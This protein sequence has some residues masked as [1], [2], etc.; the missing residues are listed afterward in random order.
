MVFS[1]AAQWWI[2][3]AVSVCLV[4]VWVG[5]LSRNAQLGVDQTAYVRTVSMMQGGEGYYASM[6][7]GLRASIGTP[8]SEVRAFRLPT[9]FWFWTYTHTFSWK[10]AI[11]V[12]VLSAWMVGLLTWPL[13]GLAVEL[14]LIN[15][16]HPIGIQQ[17][18]DVEF[19]TLPIALAGVVA[20]RREA[21]G[22]ALAAALLAACIREQAAL[23]LLGGALATWARKE[24]IWPWVCAT[25]AWA[26]FIVWH[27]HEASRYTVPW[28]FQYPLIGGSL[29]AVI[30]MAGPWLGILSPALVILA[31]WRGR[32]TAQW[33]FVL[34]EVTVIP[35]LG[36][37]L[38][39]AYWGVLVLPLA[40]VLLKTTHPAGVP[41]DVVV[42][43][44]SDYLQRHERGRGG[45]L[46]SEVETMRAGRRP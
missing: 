4:V 7:A 1:R 12:I 26:G 5:P 20:I 38:Y 10:I 9:I 30:D 41:E 16:A 18:A 14:W 42:L 24:R 22:W 11:A 8:A 39:R 19:W 13:L 21:W 28:G 44:E 45:R 23:L 25:F 17:W 32:L 40:L 33:W 34:P 31:V 2:F 46:A 3:G 15:L 37:F 36:L 35:L 6:D 27:A 29:A 43:P